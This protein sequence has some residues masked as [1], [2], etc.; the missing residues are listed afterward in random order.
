MAKSLKDFRVKVNLDGWFIKGVGTFKAG[1]VLTGDSI[2]EQVLDF[3]E[4]EY[5]FKHMSGNKL[6]VCLLL[7]DADLDELKAAFGA[8][9]DKNDEVV[10]EKP[11]DDKKGDEKLEDEKPDDDDDDE[12]DD[13][14]DDDEDDDEDEDDDDEDEKEKVALKKATTPKKIIRRAP[15]KRKRKQYK[16]SSSKE[17]VIDAT[18]DVEDIEE[19]YREESIKNF[20]RTTEKSI[21]AYLRARGF[22]YRGVEKV[23]LFNGRG[24][25]KVI[26]R[27]CFDGS[28]V[29]KRSILEYYNIGD[30]DKHTVNAKRFF[31]EFKNVNSIIMNF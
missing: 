5:T 20:Y 18:Y 6:R 10:A 28:D 23:I 30:K 1:T 17:K 9:K 21:A 29:T 26:V 24:R 31:Q 14:D 25:E 22:L 11:K 12:D 16:M 27:F 4:K 19:E 2:N 7:D 8:V 3:L 15:A 13:E